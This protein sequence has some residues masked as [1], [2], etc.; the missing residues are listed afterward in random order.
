MGLPL[1]QAY[2][3]GRTGVDLYEPTT[4][5]F[6]VAAN[7]IAGRHSHTATLLP[8]GTVLIAGGHSIYPG[9][10]ASAEIYTPT[11]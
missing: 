3:Y 4:G 2:G 1:G 7:M 5:D 8:D 10:T 11:Q 6:V 9:S